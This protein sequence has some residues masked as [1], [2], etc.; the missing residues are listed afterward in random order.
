MHLVGAR[1]V[2][3]PEDGALEQR[4]ALADLGLCGGVHRVL[5]PWVLGCHHVNSGA[6]QVIRAVVTTR[7]AEDIVGGRPPPHG[8]GD[9]FDVA[10]IPVQPGAEDGQRGALAQRC[11]IDEVQLG[12]AHDVAFVPVAAPPAVLG[13]GVAVHSA[14]AHRVHSF[15]IRGSISWA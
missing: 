15:S 9:L 2:T 11:G 12:Y 13:M 10:V 14:K 1:P 3:S 6:R 8:G 7:G 5:L 4:Q